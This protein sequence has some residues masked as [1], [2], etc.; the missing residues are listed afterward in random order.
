MTD[1]WLADSLHRICPRSAPE[2]RREIRLELLRGER[3]SF[4]IACR[5]A[6]Q[7]VTIE[8][9]VEAPVGI[10]TRV[11]RIGYVPLPHIDTGL[12]ADAIE[13]LEHL[14][15]FVPDP[16]LPDVSVHAGPFETN[17]FWVSLSVDADCPPGSYEIEA[18]LSGPG[19]ELARFP[20]RVTVHSA[21]IPERRD[22]PVTNW[23]Y[24]NALFDWYGTDGFDERFWRLLD[25]YF[26]NL[27]EHG[28]DTIYSPI[29]TPPLDGEKRPTQLVGVE[30]EGDRYTFDWSLVRRWIAT[31]KAAGLARF[32]WSHL[33]SQWGAAQA[34]A[35]YT[36]HGETGERLWA[37]ATP[38]TSKTYRSF[39]S[40]FLP[41]FEA[42]LRAERVLEAS[43]FHLSDEPHGAD[44]IEQ[45][46]AAREMVRDI[47]PWMPVMDALSDVTYA[48]KGLIDLPVALLPAVPAFRAGGFPVWAYYCNQPRGHYLNRFLETPLSTIRMTGWLLYASGAGGFLNW[49]YNSWYGWHSLDLIDPFLVT[50]AG[51]WP[52]WTYGDPFV[53]YP[54]PDGPLDSIRW[55][56]FAESLQDYAILQASGITPND[57]FLS[58][59]ID[60]ETFPRDAEWI[61]EHRARLIE[62]LR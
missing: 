61:R 47:A 26:A 46:R 14:P 13:G 57:P 42:C 43:F 37:P 36:G 34:I 60:F 18:S 53:V 33:V 4:Q 29:F 12:P 22:F 1:C 50:D 62:R 54:G 40:Q 3:G 6:E 7:P 25:P 2:P 30:R 44:H 45:Y 20:V 17:S 49:A 41:A 28:Q 15:G 51:V 55:A 16:L 38:A 48:E 32:E 31:A 19:G 39:L 9:R 58:D 52:R 35:I 8:A 10:R 21:A 23:F 5:T 24:A 11:R 27:V 59:L 56:I